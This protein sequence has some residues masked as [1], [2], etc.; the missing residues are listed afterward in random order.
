MATKQSVIL[1]IFK[2]G[3]LAG[4]AGGL[5]EMVWVSAYAA[6]TGGDAAVLAR[7]VT[8]AS[9]LTALLPATSVAAGIGIHMLL[10]VALGLALAGLWQS[11]SS[12]VHANGLYAGTLA[13]LAGVWAT[14][15]FV[16]LPA[17]SP[18]FVHLVPYSVSL[19]SK[20][21]FGLAAAEVFR[22]YVTAG[23]RAPSSQA[24]A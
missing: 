16:L 12:R 13:I 3:V 21:L 11:L 7:G 5:A 1:E 20:L 17:I 19:M 2:R 8:T 24:A 9:G 18:E 23:A 4:A 6:L 22:R 10:A 14:N 15:F